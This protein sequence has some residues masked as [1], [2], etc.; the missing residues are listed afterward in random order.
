MPKFRR[1]KVIWLTKNPEFQRVIEL[2]GTGDEHSC[3][4]TCGLGQSGFGTTSS[5]LDQAIVAAQNAGAGTSTSRFN[6]D[7]APVNLPD[8]VRLV[9][10][11]NG[12]I[13]LTSDAGDCVLI[14]RAELEALERALEILSDSSDVQQMRQDLARVVAVAIR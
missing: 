13:E 11:R 14:T 4:N 3:M 5:Q 1:P 9:L 12:R 10:K 7:V 2:F 8:L 6:V